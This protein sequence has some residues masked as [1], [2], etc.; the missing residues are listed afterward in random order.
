MTISCDIQLE[1]EASE[2][3]TTYVI[4]MYFRSDKIN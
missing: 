3:L 2:H 1:V 4:Y